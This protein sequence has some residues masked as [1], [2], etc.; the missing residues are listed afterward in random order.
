MHSHDD[1]PQRIG[2]AEIVG[3]PHQSKYAVQQDALTVVEPSPNFFSMSSKERE[4]IYKK[5]FKSANE[6]VIEGQGKKKIEGGTTG[7][8]VGASFDEGKGEGQTLRVHSANLGDSTAFLIVYDSQGKINREKSRM[9]NAL[10]QPGNSKE[11]ARVA[12]EGGVIAQHGPMLRLNGKF[13]CTRSLEGTPSPGLGTE[14]EYIEETVQLNDDEHAMLLVSCDGMLEEVFK[15]TFDS[16]TPAGRQLYCNL[17]LDHIEKFI[18][19][20][21]LL[22]ME[23]RAVA[24]KLMG[25]SIQISADNISMLVQRLLPSKPSLLMGVFDGHGVV[26]PGLND[27]QNNLVGGE[28]AAHIAAK[29]ISRF[30]GTLFAMDDL[31]VVERTPASID[32]IIRYAQSRRQRTT[33]KKE[34]DNDEEKRP[35]LFEQVSEFLKQA[36]LNKD[37]V[38]R[39]IL[40]IQVFDQELREA[41][42]PEVYVKLC[43]Q[44]LVTFDLIKNIAG[45]SEL[46]ENKKIEKI[47]DQI[48]NFVD[49]L[50][51]Y[52][53]TSNRMGC[54]KKAGIAA[55]RLIGALLGLVLTP[56]A[57]V[58]A[59]T[60][61]CKSYLKN[62]NPTQGNY[63]RAVGIGFVGVILGVVAAPFVAMN[64]CDNLVKSIF[65]E[66]YERDELAQKVSGPLAKMKDKNLLFS[67]K[68]ISTPILEKGDEGKKEEN[69]IDL[70]DES[71]LNPLNNK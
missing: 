4:K 25:M 14:P 53:S 30:L 28:V 7:L 54:G 8:I 3:S 26:Y 21:D 49:E 11:E 36:G 1:L 66:R 56:F 37:E 69:Q 47:N 40:S 6:K 24:S 41:T 63:L 22:T 20:H 46:D 64:E 58:I 19:P 31:L 18:Q 17:A 52:A 71:D 70:R 42:K 27:N 48:Q 2:G 5:A 34:S 29:E 51:K 35:S 10:H 13:A 44:I 67:K 62:K 59:A 32:A 68:E 39:I 33:E 15:K 61:L 43:N 23:P 55:C 65:Y 57:P 60:R 38:D 16:S 45:N 50:S 9:L 12:K